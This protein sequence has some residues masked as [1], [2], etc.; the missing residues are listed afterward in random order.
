MILRMTSGVSLALALAR[1]AAAL[2]LALSLVVLCGGRAS[3]NTINFDF[4]N[5]TPDSG[6]TCGGL[7]QCAL[8]GTPAPQAFTLL[9][10]TITATGY[11]NLTPTTSATPSG[12]GYVTQKP[13]VFDPAGGETGIG[14]SE[15]G[16]NGTT[17][18]D[19]QGNCEIYP[20]HAV[21]LDAR[22][23]IAHG[24]RPISLTIE[25]LQLGEQA[26]VFAANAFPLATTQVTLTGGSSGETYTVDLTTWPETGLIGIVGVANNS[27]VAQLVMSTPTPE[28]ASWLVLGSGLLCVGLL[29]RRRG[30]VA[31]RELH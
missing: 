17:C 28:P 11:V 14:V 5:I 8:G 12:V 30:A 29:R 2:V 6:A 18:S 19:P 31:R 22:D 1:G 27:L 15:T 26:T 25:S 20:G 10:V 16:F 3:A 7:A 4:G 24:Y 13:G 23:A 21:V 9:G